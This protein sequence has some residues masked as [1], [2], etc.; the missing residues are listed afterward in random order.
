MLPAVHRM[1]HSGD[2]VKTVRLG[3]RFGGSLLVAHVWQKPAD[4]GT[5]ELPPAR[6]GLIVSRAVG[7]AVIRT[8]VKRRL[9]AQVAAR[10][11][12][13][14]AGSLW[15]FRAQNSCSAASSDQLGQSIQALVERSLRRRGK[16]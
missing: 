14:P 3:A 1:Q 12:H 13:L 5:T 4:V 8:R 2:F 16:R 6:V 9:R 11:S 10:V 15:V 7:G